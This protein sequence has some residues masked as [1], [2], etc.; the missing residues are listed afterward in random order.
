MTILS[1]FIHPDHF[2][3]WGDLALPVEMIM[4]SVPFGDTLCNSYGFHVCCSDSTFKSVFQ[5]STSTANRS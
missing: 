3:N 1:Q 4:F 5:G 2:Y